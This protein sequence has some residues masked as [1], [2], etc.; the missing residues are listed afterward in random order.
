MLNL[1]NKFVPMLYYGYSAKVQ[2]GKQKIR[3]H[4]VKVDTP[5]S[6]G[7]DT[8]NECNAPMIGSVALFAFCR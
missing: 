5:Y 1:D 6:P 2:T 4:L 8:R 7:K 3:Q